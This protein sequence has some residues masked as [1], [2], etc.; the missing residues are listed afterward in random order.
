MN[1]HGYSKRIRPSNFIILSEL[2]KAQRLFETAIEKGGNL[3][4]GAEEYERQAAAAETMLDELALQ[5]PE[6]ATRIFMAS[7][8]FDEAVQP[9]QVYIGRGVFVSREDLEVYD[10]PE[11]LEAL[12]DRKGR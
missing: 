9:G 1:Q 3:T 12:R 11:K 8:Y 10:T 2:A 5:D 4:S 7:P 6:E